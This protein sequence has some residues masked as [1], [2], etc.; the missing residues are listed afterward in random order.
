MLQTNNFGTPFPKLSTKRDTKK[1]NVSH[2]SER[3]ARRLIK[4]AENSKHFEEGTNSEKI[5]AKAPSRVM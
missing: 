3:A 1:P 2:K 5:L 4:K